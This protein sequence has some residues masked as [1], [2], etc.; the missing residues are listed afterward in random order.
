MPC[1][2]RWSLYWALVP[3]VDHGLSCRTGLQT[4]HTQLECR[5]FVFTYDPLTTSLLHWTELLL[6]IHIV[7]S[8]LFNLFLEVFNHLSERNFI[9][10]KLLQSVVTVRKRWKYHNTI[11][12]MRLWQLFYECPLSLIWFIIFVWSSVFCSKHCLD[13]SACLCEWFRIFVLLT[14]KT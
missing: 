3:F 7:S 13:R 5:C 10:R 11:M 6:I 1:P 9:L 14:L 4:W 2:S 12:L 8:L